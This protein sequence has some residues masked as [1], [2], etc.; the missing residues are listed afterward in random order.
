VCGFLTNA[1]AAPIGF[2]RYLITC[3]GNAHKLTLV[4]SVSYELTI[5]D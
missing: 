4:G 5:A 3:G 1:A 2:Y